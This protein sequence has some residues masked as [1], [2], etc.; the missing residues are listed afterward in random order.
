MEFLG[1]V[2]EGEN[3]VL[4]VLAGKIHCRYVQAINRSSTCPIVLRMNSFCNEST[5]CGVYHA[6]NTGGRVCCVTMDNK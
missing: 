5:W 2:D 6:R 1:G 4:F 3:K